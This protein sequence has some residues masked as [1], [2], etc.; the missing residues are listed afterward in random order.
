MADRGHE[1]TDEL[2]AD[3][4]ERIAREYAHASRDMQRKWVEYM[5]KF[6][7]EDAK[8]KALLD[9]GKITQADYSN[10]R[11]RHIMMGKRWEAMKD[12]L[13]A[14][15][16]KVNEIALRIADGSMADVYC[17]NA[18]FAT[19]QIEHGAKIN[20]G[21]TLYNHDAAERLLKSPQQMMPGPSTRKAA[22]IAADKTMQWNKRRIQSAV[23]QGVLQGESPYKVAERLRSV[24]TM[25][26][27]ASVRY[28][29]TMTT[30]AQNAGRYDSFRRAD[31]LGVDL[32][33][34]WQATLDGRTRHEHRMMHGQRRDVDEPFIL[35]GVKILYP[36]QS[37]GEG[38]S[39]IPQSM[40][41]NCR[42]TLLAWVKG[43]EGDTV[44]ESPKMGDMTFEEWLE[45]KAP[46][47][48]EPTETPKPSAYN[49]TRID[50]QIAE[51][52]PLNEYEYWSEE[53]DRKRFNAIKAQTG[54]DD[55]K[56]EMTLHA[57]SGNRNDY[58]GLEDTP[59]GWFY[60]AD[61]RIRKLDGEKWADAAKTIDEYIEAA[62]KYDGPIYR[63]MSLSDDKIAAFQ[64]GGIFQDNGSLSS[65]T[66]SLDVANMFAEGRTEEYGLNP[67]I[68]ETIGHPHSSPVAHLSLFG[69]EEDE[70]LVSNLHGNEYTID[71][72]EKRG[73][74]LFVRL[75]F[76]G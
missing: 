2:L 18:D 22:Q 39:D 51:T 8:Q 16:E 63:G 50:H 43:F 34:E 9:A 60:R 3:L 54:F 13:A 55:E 62:P 40:V 68:I 64:K 47:R 24:A 38:S 41:W 71:S 11:F 69:S 46:K 65:W 4:E 70:V 67:V 58:H 74:V 66:S 61:R 45:D 76:G 32:V 52:P 12:T 37:S 27:N 28:A 59:E 31:K 73:G 42:C 72:V 25:N 35:D 10:W 6:A 21:Y 30:N 17:L 29:R 23:L 49:A 56:A 33:I 5:E 26:Y 7:A 20:T 75:I 48:Q 15:M 36:A 19:Y 53:E 44:K 1:L 57:F 14:D